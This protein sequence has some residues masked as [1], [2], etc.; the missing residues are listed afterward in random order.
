MQFNEMKTSIFLQ[1][2]IFSLSIIAILFILLSS[3]HTVSAQTDTIPGQQPVFFHISHHQEDV[4]RYSTGFPKFRRFKENLKQELNLLDHYGV[5]SDQCFS[6]FIVSVILYKDST[7]DPGA[8]SIFYW[9][10]HSNQNLGYHFHPSTWDIMIRLDKIKDM[11]LDQGIAEY[12]KW[13][14]AYYDWSDCDSSHL[15][16]SI[17][18]GKLDTTRLGGIQLMQQYF[19]KPVVNEC[20]TMLNPAAGQ[21]IRNKFGSQNPIIGQAG[22][23][24]SYYTYDAF[25]NLWV[26][27]W[28]FSNEPGIYVYKMMGNY[29]IQNRSVAWLEGLMDVEMLQQVL[30][31]LPREIPHIFAIHLTV[32]PEGDS[33]LK[34]HLKYLTREFLPNNPGSCFISTS[35]IPDII[36]TNSYEFSMSDLEAACIYTLSQ[37]H[38]RPPAF[39]QYND[40]YT[41][42]AALYIALQ[43]TINTWHNSPSPRAWPSSVRVPEFIR[44]P[45]G[46]KALTAPS[47]SRL[48]DGFP[49]GLMLQAIESQNSSDSIPYYSYIP[50]IGTPMQTNASEFLNGMCSIFLRLRQGD[51]SIHNLLYILPSYIIPISYLPV[52]TFLNDTGN[53]VA[54]TNMDWLSALQLW[55]IEAVRLKTLNKLSIT[56][57][58]KTNHDLDFQLLQNYPNPF[59]EST[60]IKF[61]VSKRMN[62]HLDVFD[63]MGKNIST[64][65][66]GNFYP[67]WHTVLWNGTSNCGNRCNGNIF[68]IRLTTE[69]GSLQKKAVMIR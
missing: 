58:Q 18:C 9:F 48:S 27:D 64:L 41:S 69:N 7:D 12:T 49:F 32:P 25:Q 13:E 10:N 63:L 59:S 35:E 11:D 39:V 46:R 22:N 50:N 26:S 4:G 56:D 1:C 37:W 6:D 62:L 8:D 17:F 21:V 30:A 66:A 43:N 57:Y 47:D 24:H 60:T 14:K 40:K 20:L 23:I 54:Y 55:T 67:G 61:F 29:Y 45:L 68:F 53:H 31:V 16:T 52:E 38:G 2:K 36:D 44:P 33:T 15:D 5:V 65:A 19:T 3:L 28:M 42:L 51:T 34:Q